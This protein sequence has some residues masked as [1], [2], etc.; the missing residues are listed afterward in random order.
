MS[1][2]STA[3]VMSAVGDGVLA[4]SRS[5]ARP[6]AGR[7]G[8]SPRSRP[9]ATPPTTRPKF[10]SRLPLPSSARR[11]LLA[12]GRDQ[13]PG[14]EE[15]DR[16][17]PGDLPEP[18]E[19]GRDR[20]DQHRRE[21]RR[22]GL[23]PRAGG[24]APGG[25]ADPEERPEQGE[26]DQPADQ[27]ELGER[28]QVER[29]GVDHVQVDRAQLLPGELVGAGAVAEQRLFFEGVDRD[30]PEVVAAG[31]GEVGEM[32]GGVGG[33]LEVGARELVPGAAAEDDRGDDRDDAERRA[34]RSFS[35]FGSRES[36][37]RA[38]SRPLRRGPPAAAGA[39]RARAS[40]G[41]ARRAG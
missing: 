30:P 5:R 29:V 20:E 24:G 26:D 13:R 14:G 34:R 32:L 1:A 31:A 11:D 9:A 12:A 4:G 39:R 37:T 10:R 17:Q 19:A 7:R 22:V 23:A 15:E 40:Q 3:L 21:E 28:L 16:A 36:S 25:Y 2:W 8:R 35:T 6:A 18:V 33:E 41:G 38:G 27:A